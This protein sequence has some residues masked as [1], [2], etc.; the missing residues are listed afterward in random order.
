VTFTDNGTAVPGGPSKVN[1]YGYT[2]DYSVQLLGGSHTLVA[3]FTTGDLSYKSGSSTP[4]VITVN[5]AP[6][7]FS[8]VTAPASAGLNQNFTVTATLATT[9]YGVAPAGTVKFFA[10]GVQLPGTVTYTPTNGGVSGFAALGASLT[11]SISTSGS[12]TITA[13]YSGDT[14]YTSQA[15]SPS[16]VIQVTG[17]DF[18]IAMTSTP[19][20]TLAA[21]NVQWSGTLTAVNGYNKLVTLSC[22]AGA[23]STCIPSAPLMPTAG[24]AP[25]TVTVGSSTPATYTFTISGTDGTLVHAT[26]K[27]TL[28]VNPDFTV[29]GTLNPPPSANP[30][31]TTSTTMALDTVP[32]GGNFTSN[33]TYTCSSGLPAGATCSFTPAQINAGMPG[34]SVTVTVQTAGPFTGTA[35]SARPRLRSQK[36]PLWLPLSL[37]LAGVVLVGLAGRRMPRRYKIVG[38]CLALALTGLLVACG[39]GS[40]SPP[41]AVVTVTPPTT[42]SN[43]YPNLTVNP[44]TQTHQFAATVSNSTSQTV[45]WAV[46]GTGNGSIDPNSGLYTAPAALPNPNSPITITATS[47]AATSPGTATVNLLA[48]TPAGTYNPI[49]VTITEGATQHATTFSLTVN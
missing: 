49:T 22:T 33:V 28:T 35:S 4:V 21:Q 42:V 43:L 40:S 17:P 19:S 31:Q 45:T 46:T 13:T 44:P 24:G 14:N 18:T 23:P 39:G 11:T 41:P 37:P 9:S 7:T 2:D 48:P 20:P 3:H 25:F 38:L 8:S 1:S 10:N 27:E 15:S 16:A 47:T 12:Y 30:G 29:P 26:P 6:T 32:A 36:Q 34:Q 5:T